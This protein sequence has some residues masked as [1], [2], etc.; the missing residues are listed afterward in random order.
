[1]D[2]ETICPNHPIRLRCIVNTTY[3]TEPSPFL[4]WKCTNSSG[5][6]FL[7]C[8]NMNILDFYCAFGKVENIIGSCPCGGSS[9]IASEATFIPNSSAA[10]T[11]V[12]SD[13]TQH[14]EVS[15]LPRGT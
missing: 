1:M 7:I 3:S 11:L 15:I 13:G 2:S 5:D 6:N 10:R 12:C 14:E 4:S 8:N 9:V